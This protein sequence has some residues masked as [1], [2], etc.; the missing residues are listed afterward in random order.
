MA[1]ISE[2]SSIKLTLVLGLFSVAGGAVWAG[3]GMAARMDALERA[4]TEDRSERKADNQQLRAELR[5][6]LSGVESR[7]QGELAVMKQDL[8]DVKRSTDA[9]LEHLL[10]G[11]KRP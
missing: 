7:M 5:G 4:Q 8:R 1:A 3:G 9:I 6:E 11:P 2:N 10:K